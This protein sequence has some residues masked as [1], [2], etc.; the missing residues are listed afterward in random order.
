[1]RAPIDE[2]FLNNIKAL[3]LSSLPNKDPEEFN[4]SLRYLA[5][6][7]RG[8]TNHLIE[9]N[10]CRLKVSIGGIDYFLRV[11]KDKS[12]LH[13]ALILDSHRLSDL[14]DLNERCCNL[15]T[16]NYKYKE[17]ASQVVIEGH[18]LYKAEECVVKFFYN[19]LVHFLNSLEQANAEHLL[20]LTYSSSVIMNSIKDL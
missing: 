14:C 7:A 12:T 5:L 17:P 20:K 6:V 9:I 13:E 1:L 18:V 10:K 4:F 11:L 3:K 19:N 16:I 8:I 2:T 15:L